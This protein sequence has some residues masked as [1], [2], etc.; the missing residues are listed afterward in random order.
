[1]K[2]AYIQRFLLLGYLQVLIIGEKAVY[3]LI[4]RLIRVI[5]V[6]LNC[7]NIVSTRTD[8]ISITFNNTKKKLFIKYF[9][10]KDCLLF[11]YSLL[12]HRSKLLVQETAKKIPDYANPR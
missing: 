7:A 5:G 10:V 4:L 9:P 2:E 6:V 1:M 12:W 11:E 3:F 8:K